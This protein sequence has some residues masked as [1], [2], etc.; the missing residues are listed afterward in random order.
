MS[1]WKVD[2]LKKA[3]SDGIVNTFSLK[4]TDGNE[5]SLGVYTFGGNYIRSNTSDVKL[6]SHSTSKKKT[7]KKGVKESK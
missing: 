6:T 1:G 3:K 7:N 5:Y 2:W 4:D